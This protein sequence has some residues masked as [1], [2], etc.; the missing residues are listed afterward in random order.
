MIIAWCLWLLGA[1]GVALLSS[2]GI[3]AV[4]W[5]VLASVIGLMA[6]W[7]A[8]RLSQAEQID[9][10]RRRP[11]AALAILLEWLCLVLVFQMVI[12]PLRI[13]ADWP[14]RQ[15]LWLNAAVAAWSLLTAAAVAW[16][17]QFRTS[18]GRTVMMAVCMLVLVG[19]PALMALTP[20]SG[21]SPLRFVWTMR[22]SPLQALWAMTAPSPGPLEPWMG[23]ILTITA[24]AVAAWLVLFV[25]AWLNRGG[26]EK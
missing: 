6:M 26:D 12:W 9:D 3:P 16:G 23:V 13:V 4:R 25:F 10:T 18:L 2:S 17:R 19:E 5:T 20:S 1:W 14:V 8:A 11:Q 22:L 7:P 15:A 24:A 21:P